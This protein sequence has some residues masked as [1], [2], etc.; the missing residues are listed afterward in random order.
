M[1]E[2]TALKP[3]VLVVDDEVQIRRLL[4][5]ALEANGYRMIEAAGGQDGL[6]QAATRRP[7]VVLLDLGLPDLDGVTVIKRLREWS[8]VPVVV[9]SV[10]ERDEDK[11]AAL[12]QG[13]DDYV[14]KPF[15]TAELLARLRVALRHALPA[16]DSA[17]FRTGDLE[18]DL[19]SR[20][21]TLK[22]EEVRLT[23]TEYALLRLLV[24]HAGKV[25][26]HRHLLQEAWGPDYVGQTHYLR[27]YMAR[28]REKL[29]SVPSEPELIIT[30]LGVGYRLLLKE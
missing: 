7:D 10:R 29:E 26:T 6:T 27:V 1:S 13:A 22:G 14:T 20:R 24:R 9:L 16:T 4:R 19:A 5:I 17:V 21:V 2:E 30:E 15:S 18:V 28:L 25:L 23:A 12:D 8:H 3:V 11:I